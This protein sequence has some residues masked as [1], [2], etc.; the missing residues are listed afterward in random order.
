MKNKLTQKNI[1]LVI[2]YIAILTTGIIFKQPF[3][4]IA[5]LFISVVVMTLQAY[6]NRFGYLLGGINAIIYTVIYIQL[7]AYATAISGLVISFPMQLI[8][9]FY[10]NKRPYEKSVIFKKMSWKLQLLSIATFVISCA[11][12]FGV[13]KSVG[14]L[15][16][17]LDTLYSIIGIYVSVFTMFAFVEYSYLWPINCVIGVFL[18]IQI[19]INEPSQIT[20]LIYSVYSLYCVMLAFINVQMIYKKQKSEALENEN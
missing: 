9:F 3:Y 17:V 1:V 16:T 10:W 6:A 13:L 12:C 2:T 7:G 14:S 11:I 20:Y 5:P 15:Y 18:N 4:R 19:A 8:T